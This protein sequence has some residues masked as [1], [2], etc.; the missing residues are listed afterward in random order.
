MQIVNNVM[1]EGIIKFLNKILCKL[2]RM[3]AECPQL[4]LLLLLFEEYYIPLRTYLMSSR[5]CL[6]GVQFRWAW[7][8]KIME[9]YIHIK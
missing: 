1:R 8:I 3:W 4:L 2:L 6:S 7:D 9:G 5:C